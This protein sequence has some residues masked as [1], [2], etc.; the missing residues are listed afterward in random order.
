MPLYDAIFIAMELGG[1]VLLTL[2]AIDLMLLLTLEIIKYGNFKN[3]VDRSKVSSG[4]GGRKHTRTK[5]RNKSHGVEVLE[6][7]PQ[8]LSTRF[9][10][11]RARSV[12][13]Y[14]S[15]FVPTRHDDTGAD[16]VDAHSQP[17][18]T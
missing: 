10:P 1:R 2:L 14:P 6:V 4:Q 15:I 11:F 12:I 16:G 13:T 3:R 8:R 5:G 17:R 9:N 7:N 18:T